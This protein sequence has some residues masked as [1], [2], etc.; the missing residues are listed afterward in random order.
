MSVEDDFIKSIKAD[1]IN[2]IESVDVDGW[3]RPVEKVNTQ[4]QNNKC[5]F[6]FLLEDLCKDDKFVPIDGSTQ[7]TYRKW[8]SKLLP[9]F[10]NILGNKEDTIPNSSF[11]EFKFKSGWGESLEYSVWRLYIVFNIHEM[12]AK[13][14]E[15]KINQLLG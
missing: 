5:Y 11:T 13:Q 6:N 8:S 7:K 14:R 3:R 9:I 12:I 1:W 10:E 2:I 4:I 15:I